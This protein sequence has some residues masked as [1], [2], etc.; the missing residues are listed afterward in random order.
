MMTHTSWVTFTFLSVM[1]CLRGSSSRAGHQEYPLTF[2]TSST[3][4]WLILRD[5]GAPRAV[6][7]VAGSGS[8]TAQSAPMLAGRS[9]S[10]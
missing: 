10:G 6:Q 3:G 5:L 2:A 7:V 4:G 9:A 1:P 8:S